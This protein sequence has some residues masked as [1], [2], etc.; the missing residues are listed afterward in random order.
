MTTEHHHWYDFL[1]SLF[2]W[3][4]WFLFYELNFLF[5]SVLQWYSTTT[6]IINIKRLLLCYSMLTPHHLRLSCKL[7]LVK[8][9]VH[10]VSVHNGFKIRHIN[11]K[12]MYEKYW[13]LFCDASDKKIVTHLF[14]Y[15]V[16]CDVITDRI[17]PQVTLTAAFRHASQHQLPP[18]LLVHLWNRHTTQRRHTLLYNQHYSIA[19]DIWSS[20][21]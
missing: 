13:E 1:S 2:K 17:V 20:L 5:T 7:I 21:H 6:K 14:W 12:F 16:I 19:R 11:S 10:V 9:C 3:R 15:L 8:L 4:K 18:L